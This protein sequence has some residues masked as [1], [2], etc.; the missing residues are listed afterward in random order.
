M[1]TRLTNADL[2]KA[3]LMSGGINAVIN[4]LINWFQVKG[5]SEIFLT[6]DSISTTEHTVLGGAVIHLILGNNAGRIDIQT[7]IQLGGA[8]NAPGY[9]STIGIGKFDPVLPPN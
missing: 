2:V 5:K 4:G 7:D 1:T 9:R 3:A 6:V 8:C